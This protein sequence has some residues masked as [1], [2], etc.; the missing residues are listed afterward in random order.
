MVRSATVASVLVAPARSQDQ[1]GSPTSAEAETEREHPGQRCAA[2]GGYH[3]QLRPRASSAVGMASGADGAVGELA[4]KTH[5]VSRAKS[6]APP[7]AT[8]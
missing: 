8:D 4:P 2:P 6:T 3:H 1:P 5:A 7:M